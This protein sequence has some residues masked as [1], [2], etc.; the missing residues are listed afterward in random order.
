MEV[1]ANDDMYRRFLQKLDVIVTLYN[2]V[3]KSLNHVELP[4]VEQQLKAI[5]AL[6]E[7]ATSELTWCSEGECED[8]MS[9]IIL[10]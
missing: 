1:Y 2:S 5:D 7:R 4:L 10:N 6:L 3:K 8:G 9:V